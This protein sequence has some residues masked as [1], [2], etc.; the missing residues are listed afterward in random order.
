MQ[1]RRL[2][3][4]D[5]FIRIL[6]GLPESG[7]GYQMVKVILKGGK[8]LRQHK[9]LNS[10]ILILEE[11]EDFSEVDIEKIELESKK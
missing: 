6:T 4:P 9:V 8:T 1:T 5:D 2:K 7:M 11:N 3:L 10:S